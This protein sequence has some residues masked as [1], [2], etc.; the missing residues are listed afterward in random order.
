MRHCGLFDQIKLGRITLAQYYMIMRA[1]QLKQI[2]EQRNI[3]LQA[4]LNV[5]AK[6]TKEKG[7]KIVPHFKT[8]NDF[9]KDPEVEK[10][11]K[12]KKASKDKENKK[13]K[14]MILR[15]NVNKS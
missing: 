2:D 11:E 4:W 6:A 10:K 1:I 9:F 8:F 7:K 15:T 14:K 5:Q 3:H 12:M 13:K